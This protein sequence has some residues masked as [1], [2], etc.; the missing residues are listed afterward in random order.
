LGA[1][2]TIVL[3]GSGSL[4]SAGAFS[5]TTVK[6]AA[7]TGVGSLF[8]AGL[9]GPIVAIV[10]PGSGSHFSAGLFGPVDTVLIV[11]A[12]SLFSAGQLTA[13][14]PPGGTTLVGVGS[15]FAAGSFSISSSA[16]QALVG[17][18]SL[19]AAGSLPAFPFRALTGP[20]SLF[21]AGSFGVVESS[22]LPIT[23]IGSKFAP[24]ILVFSVPGTQALVG[25]GSG[26]AVS[27]LS[28]FNFVTPALVGVGS[29]YGVG[30]LVISIAGEL[31]AFGRSGSAMPFRIMAS[32]MERNLPYGPDFS[33]MD[34]GETI[35]GWMD[36]YRWLQPGESIASVVSVQV[37]NSLPAGGSPYVM[38]VGAPA[39]GTA[40]SN[41]GGSGQAGMAILQQWEGLA[42]G[43]VLVE[44]TFTTSD[45]QTLSGWAHQPVIVPN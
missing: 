5:P 44:I 41:I 34:V 37:S 11:G 40:A 42:P 19:F 16:A 12:G 29:R 7:L 14:I 15:I 8:S 33:P 23:G 13:S 21:A 27:A 20:G 36:F 22:I 28:S 10:L 1:G 25:V 2:P 45:G 3:P 17:A 32:L 38:T 35:T 24:G 43:T 9:F 30:S 39:V 4:F 6:S 31:V 26:F 18:G